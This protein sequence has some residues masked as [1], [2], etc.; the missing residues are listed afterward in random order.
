MLVA[1]IIIMSDEVQTSTRVL[2]NEEIPVIFFPHYRSKDTLRPI[3]DNLEGL[4]KKKN[5]LPPVILRLS[6]G[7]D[8]QCGV[9][10][11]SPSLQ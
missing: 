5:N 11:A 1:T 7:N 6:G 2:S 9:R 8:S 10:S 3:W 4:I